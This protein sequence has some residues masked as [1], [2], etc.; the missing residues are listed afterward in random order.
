LNSPALATVN[1]NSVNLPAV[2]LGGNPAGTV[3]LTLFNA[4][5]TRFI[6]LEL[7]ALEAD[8][9][10]KIISSPRVVTADAQ[11]ALIEQGEEIPYQQATSSGATAVQFKKANLKLEVTPQ[12][13]PDGN[14]ILVVDVTKDSRGAPLANGSTLVAIN[15]KHVKTNVQV[16]NGGTVV[17][18]GIYTQTETDNV[19]K[20]P[21]FGDIPVVGNL[22]KTTGRSSEKTELL[23]FITP[24]IVSDGRAKYQ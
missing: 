4:A 13:T 24:K 1:G 11:Q 22:F 12:I 19:T 23:I 10:G 3:A 5:A 6:G 8:G 21:L 2:G 15:T 9:R 18:G 7:S 20:I 17:L 16:E 14:V